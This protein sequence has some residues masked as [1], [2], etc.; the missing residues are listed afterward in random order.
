MLLI[1]LKKFRNIKQQLTTWQFSGIIDL[2]LENSIQD[3]EFCCP[4]PAFYLQV[5][6]GG[7]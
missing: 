6:Q 1:T 2:H 3:A 4:I 7:L 5:N